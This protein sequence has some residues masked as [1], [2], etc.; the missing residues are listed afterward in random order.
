[1]EK[2]KSAKG[3]TKSEINGHTVTSKHGRSDA[4]DETI[5]FDAQE[6][7]RQFG[8]LMT[9]NVV[10]AYEIPRPPPEYSNIDQSSEQMRLGAAVKRAAMMGENNS[11]IE[12]HEIESD[13]R[14]FG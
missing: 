5:M 11:N 10:Q 8:H 1:M 14:N 12:R 6:E 7:I 13:F 3:R 4:A 9:Q 2:Q